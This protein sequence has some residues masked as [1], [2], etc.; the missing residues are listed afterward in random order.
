MMNI[1]NTLKCSSYP[2]SIV[3]KVTGKEIVEKI[4][5]RNSQIIKKEDMPKVRYIKLPY[6]GI[7]SEQL[8]KNYRN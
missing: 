4:F 3:E 1:K 2:T 8:R 7:F 5:K 6:K